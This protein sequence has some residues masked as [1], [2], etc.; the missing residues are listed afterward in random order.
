M[1]ESAWIFDVSRSRQFQRKT[2]LRIAIQ[3]AEKLLLAELTRRAATIA[4]SGTRLLRVK[5]QGC[6][7]V[8]SLGGDAAC[9][10]APVT[11]M[12]GANSCACP[13]GFVSVAGDGK[14]QCRIETCGVAPIVNHDTDNLPR[15]RAVCYT[16]DAGHT[17]QGGVLDAPTEWTLNCD[18]GGT[19][20][21]GH[22]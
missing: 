14:P 19:F 8:R 22:T 13:S 1:L 10:P 2:V 9:F 18:A 12:I 7:R 3:V 21:P 4:P 5:V 6:Q 20:R 15:G 16:C 17:V 11:L